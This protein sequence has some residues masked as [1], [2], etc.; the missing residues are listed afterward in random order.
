MRRTFRRRLRRWSSRRSR[1][2]GGAAGV[3]GGADVAAHPARRR[4]SGRSS[5]SP[6][7]RPRASGAAARTSRPVRRRGRAG[8]TPPRAVDG[9]SRRL[10]SARCARGPRPRR[11]R[12]AAGRR[13]RGRGD[14][15]SE[16]P[17]TR[18]HRAS[19]AGPD[20]LPEPRR[21]MQPRSDRLADDLDPEAPG[22]VGQRLTVEVHERADV[23]RPPLAGPQHQLV[24]E[25]SRSIDV[26]IARSPPIV[27]S[28]A[29]GR[30]RDR[31][32]PP[33]SAWIAGRPVAASRPN[34]TRTVD[35]PGPTGR[36]GRRWGRPRRRDAA[37][38]P[39]QRGTGTSA[40]I[41]R[42]PP[43]TN[44]STPAASASR[45]RRSEIF[46]GNR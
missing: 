16:R 35:I 23:L 41:I 19:S 20:D 34:T 43:R 22:R 3:Q 11:S 4:G 17:P 18:V 12:P 1:P 13:E 32:C 37:R 26:V 14:R 9:S 33:R 45:P 2:V 38:A 46:A 25:L 44:T 6:P 24:Q 8:T 21:E 36:G 39:V 42:C 29:S 30:T 31:G 7:C 27:G 5:S 28:I 10:R 15:R 40:R